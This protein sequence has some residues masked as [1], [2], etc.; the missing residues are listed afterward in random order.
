MG[1]YPA[2]PNLESTTLADSGGVNLAAVDATGDLQ[3]DVN[4]FP[5][6]QAVTQSGTWTVQPGNTPNTSPWLIEPRAP[7]TLTTYSAAVLGIVAAAL[8]TDV[9]T[10]YGSGTKT[11]KITRLEFSATE[12]TAAIRDV[13]L[14]KRSA[15]NTGGT[16]S[17]ATRIPHDS[18]N[19]AATATVLSY[20]VNPASLGTSV[21]N[22][23]TAK[24]DIPATNLVGNTDRLIWIFG[25]RP[26]QAIVLR[27]TSEGLALNL[28]GV[29]SSSN[30]MNIDIEW[31]E[32]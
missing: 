31:T 27:G 15:T 4:N 22:I 25:D 9:F 18:N 12:N 32:E 8:P 23:R 26:G 11:V 2:E 10:I 6:T 7:A 30:S 16:S 29:T 28:N 3:V 19:A 14:I 20:T 5:A 24:F 21:G 1:I 17:S 13:I